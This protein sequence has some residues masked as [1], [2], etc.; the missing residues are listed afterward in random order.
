[1][2]NVIDELSSYCDSERLNAKETRKIGF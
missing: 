1:L 2:E